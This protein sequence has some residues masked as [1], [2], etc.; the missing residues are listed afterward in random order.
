MDYK[1]LDREFRD[2]SSELKY[3]FS[4]NAILGDVSG[5]VVPSGAFLDILLY[6]PEDIQFPVF[7]AEM[8]ETEDGNKM[9]VEFKDAYDNYIADATMD[10]DEDNVIIRRF[11][12]EAG[13]IVYNPKLISQLVHATHGNP[14]FF[15]TNLPIQIGRCFTYRSP[16]MTGIKDTSV[17]KGGETHRDKVFLV[18]A[19][20]VH[21]E[22]DPDDTGAVLVHLLG[23]EPS[24][25][26]PVLSIKQL[27][28]EHMWLAAHP[29]SGFKVETI[30]HGIRF[31]S[32]L[33]G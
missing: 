11:D 2:Y 1:I 4:D 20:G 17:S 29:N 26:R 16:A 7:L 23:E 6:V 27:A 12:T 13:S 24:V 21:F 10:L 19:N 25:D 15:G 9:K 8:R 28:R 33:D 18:A 32:I 31:R 22:V 14:I 5:L 3:P 30:K